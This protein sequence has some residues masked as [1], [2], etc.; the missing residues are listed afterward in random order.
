MKWFALLG[1]VLFL[2]IAVTPSI[3]ANQSI[4]QN[5]ALTKQHIPYL[6]LNLVT[7]KDMEI[8]QII[9]EVI[10]KIILNDFVSEQEVQNIVK[11]TIGDNGTTYILAKIKSSLSAGEIL[12]VP[13]QFRAKYG[14][15]VG[16]IF[17]IA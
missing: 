2:G 17:E 4:E 1:T 7:T 12:C 6:L 15:I 3:S 5:K 8:K 10:S 14:F 13:G 16:F 9:R 11:D